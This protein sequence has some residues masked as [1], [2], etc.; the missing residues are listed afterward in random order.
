MNLSNME[1]S[2]IS[3]REDGLQLLKE[4]DDGETKFLFAKEVLFKLLYKNT[5]YYKLISK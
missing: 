4:R 2:S 5:I 1:R 3:L